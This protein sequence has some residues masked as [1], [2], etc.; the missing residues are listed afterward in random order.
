MDVT[1]TAHNV[2]LDDGTLTKPDEGVE[3]SQ[4][5][6]F[7]AARRMLEL[8]FPGD[9]GSL[10]VADLG[11]LEG[12]YSVA[13]A[14]MGFQVIGIEIRESNVAACNYIKRRVSLPNLAFVRDDVWNVGRYGRFDAIFCCGLFYH[15]E[16]PRQFL[17]LLG[18]ITARALILNTHF[19]ERSLLRR[20]HEGL[21]GRWFTEF[22]TKRQ[23]LN[24]EAMRWCSWDN[25][26]SFWIQR[27]F[28]LQSIKAAGFDT[29]LE[30]YDWL[31]D[32][33]HSMMHGDYRKHR[34]GMF[35]GV[36]HQ[37]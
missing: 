26:R 28:L 33:A 30:Q 20:W 6:V 25:K 32:I 15:L 2:R 12:G 13:L 9:K 3:I 27:E 31:G 8:I 36:K 4:N 17:K 37:S 19:A 21:P 22:R 11:C 16:R 29:V 5:H 34:R 23:F 35:V 24:R 7:A 10:R 18:N 1:F 14:R